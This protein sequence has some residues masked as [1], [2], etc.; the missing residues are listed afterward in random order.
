M[1]SLSVVIVGVMLLGIVHSQD[2]PKLS[3]AWWLVSGTKSSV[4]RCPEAGLSDP[5][6]GVILRS[7]G[8][9]RIPGLHCCLSSTSAVQQCSADSVL[10]SM[11]FPVSLHGHAGSS[12]VS[13]STS[14]LATAR[15]IR[16]DAGPAREC[17]RTWPCSA[18][19]KVMFVQTGLLN[20]LG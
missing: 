3:P 17:G 13:I 6:P 10:Q 7:V 9:H 19:K 20:I 2:I 11:Q 5:G 14:V 8:S 16:W 15:P 12:D 1:C 4:G 18:L